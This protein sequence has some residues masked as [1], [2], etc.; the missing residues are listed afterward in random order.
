MPPR[1]RGPRQTRSERR[2]RSIRTPFRPRG[3][4][5]S[6]KRW[7]WARA[8]TPGASALKRRS[9]S[10]RWDR[11]RPWL[12][13][14]PPAPCSRRSTRRR[15]AAP[16]PGTA[17]GSLGS[18]AAEA[19]PTRG[20]SVER[21]TSAAADRPSNRQDRANQLG[22][23]SRSRRPCVPIP[24]RSDVATDCDGDGD[25]NGLRD[26]NVSGALLGP[27]AVAAGRAR[28]R[29]PRPRPR[30]APD[31]GRVRPPRPCD[32]LGGRPR[33]VHRPGAGAGGGG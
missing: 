4:D 12:E 25:A 29:A 3:A 6:G 31:A 1:E 10:R 21:Q 16:A 33:R 2:L 17:R 9:R 32:L 19:W 11:Y 20:R 7:A 24:A 5:C 8:S 13:G 28:P 22:T 26:G 27:H 15:G 14:P 18:N 23:T 30:A